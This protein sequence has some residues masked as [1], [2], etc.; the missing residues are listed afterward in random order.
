MIDTFWKSIDILKLLALIIVGAWIAS[1]FLHVN[2]T[3]QTLT[4]VIMIIV[5]FFFGSSAGSKKKDDAM[6]PPTEGQ[7]R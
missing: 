4:N 7:H 5:G 1:I 6:L 2:G 3:D